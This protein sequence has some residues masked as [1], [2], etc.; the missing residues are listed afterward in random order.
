VWL[1]YATQQMFIMVPRVAA[2]A[3]VEPPPSH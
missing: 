2:A 1:S 3:A